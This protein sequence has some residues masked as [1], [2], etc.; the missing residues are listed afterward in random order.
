MRFLVEVRIPMDGGNT[1]LKDGAMTEKLHNYLN[2]V[3]PEAVSF[4]AGNGQR[5]KYLV[6]DMEN[7]DNL[8][9]IV[10]PLSPDWGAEIY[11]S[12]VMTA[13]DFEKAGPTLQKVI[14]A[15]K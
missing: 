9:K 2:D 7:R 6:L 4:A 14:E 11:S 15:R 3:K 1:G 10:E 12:P 8:T 5:T 13:E